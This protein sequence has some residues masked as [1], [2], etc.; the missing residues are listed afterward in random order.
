MKIQITL[1]IIMT[2]CCTTVIAQDTIRLKNITKN[3]TSDRYKV[4]TDR[5]PQAVYVELGG[6]LGNITVNYDSRFSKRLDGLGF[7][8]GI[9]R[10]SNF[11]NFVINSEVN[12]LIGNNR[13]GRFFEIGLGHTFYSDYRSFYSEYNVRRSNQ[14]IQ[15]SIGY[16]SQPIQ[17][18][19][20]FRGGLCP[21]V[22]GGYESA[23]VYLGLG[24]NF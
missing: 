14:T 22:I 23:A 21:I 1:L 3:P 11:R 2:F 20:L 9:G 12:Y 13:K 7:R 16:R 8:L 10:S 18:G 17:G 5:A 24:Y 4:V 6:E 19:F 15:F